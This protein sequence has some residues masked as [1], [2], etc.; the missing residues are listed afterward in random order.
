[1]GFQTY[2]RLYDSCVK[3]IID[4][5]SPIWSYTDSNKTELVQHRAIG[6]SWEYIDMLHLMAFMVIWDGYLP[7]I[8]EN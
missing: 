6:P 1:M 4:Y 3:P 5:C 7:I 2:T 8:V